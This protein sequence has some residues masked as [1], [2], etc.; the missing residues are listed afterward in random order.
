MGD[1]VDDILLTYLIIDTNI[2]CKNYFLRKRFNQ[3]NKWQFTLHGLEDM[4]SGQS[5][6]GQK[7]RK[8]SVTH[9]SCD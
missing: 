6:V 1:A 4:S 2:K 8:T 7:K 3:L 9:K 5:F